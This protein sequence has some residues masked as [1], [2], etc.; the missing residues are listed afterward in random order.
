[1]MC[2][3]ETPDVLSYHTDNP[4]FPHQS[5][6]NQF[7][8]ESQTESYRELGRFTIAELCQGWDHKNG[9]A[10]LL[11]HLSKT[12]IGCEPKAARAGTAG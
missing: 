9:F 1:M 6:A 8:D 5:T 2:G 3:N 7:F 10:G 11:A 4:T 12:Y